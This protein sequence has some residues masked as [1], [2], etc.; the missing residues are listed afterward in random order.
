[1]NAKRSNNKASFDKIRAAWK[2]R[3]RELER[4]GELTDGIGNELVGTTEEELMEEFIISY[5][6]GSDSPARL[7]R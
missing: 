5:V 7:E 1:M 3:A 2:E 4:E 6:E